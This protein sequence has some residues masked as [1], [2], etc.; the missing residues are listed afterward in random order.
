MAGKMNGNTGRKYPN[1]F[2]TVTGKGFHT[3][4]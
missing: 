1:T 2:E 3:V 4:V